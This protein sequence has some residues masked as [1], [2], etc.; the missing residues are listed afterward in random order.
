ML[1][2]QLLPPLGGLAH[3]LWGARRGQAGAAP[4]PDPPPPPCPPRAT[5][6]GRIANRGDPGPDKAS[7]SALLLMF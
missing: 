5:S 1:Q 4:H 3:V 6:E 7:A 2:L